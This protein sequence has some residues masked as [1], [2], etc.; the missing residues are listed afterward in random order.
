VDLV[1][2]EADPATA[3]MT[4]HL[5]GRDRLVTYGTEMVV[6]TMRVV[7]ES[8]VENSDWCSSAMHRCS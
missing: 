2:I 7:P 6:G 8:R 5:E 3:R 1:S 4:F